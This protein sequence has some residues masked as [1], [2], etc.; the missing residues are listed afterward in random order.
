M[1][2]TRYGH[3]MCL[4]VLSLKILILGSHEHS[5]K[6]QWT[7]SSMTQSTH[8]PNWLWSRSP[9]QSTHGYGYYIYFVDAFSKFTWIYLLRNKSD[10]LQTFVNSKTK[11]NCS[12]DS[13]LS[14]YSQ[15]GVV[16]LELFQI[17]FC[18]VVLSIVPHVLILMNKMT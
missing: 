18:L 15:I 17:L 13:K 12:L 14:L 5:P 8:G 1:S 11:L 16:N 6:L 2:T 9:A 7:R 10:A 3:E 4:A